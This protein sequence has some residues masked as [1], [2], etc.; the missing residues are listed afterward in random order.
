M[1]SFT[2]SLSVYKYMYFVLFYRLKSY[3]IHVF[4][5]RGFIKI[6]QQKDNWFT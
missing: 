6:F 4:I 1:A 5:D 3:S 2:F